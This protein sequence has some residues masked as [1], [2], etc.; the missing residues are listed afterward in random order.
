MFVVGIDIGNSFAVF[1]ISHIAL[2]PVNTLLIQLWSE[3]IGLSDRVGIPFSDF[4]FLAM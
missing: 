1:V 4:Y 2:Y 3:T